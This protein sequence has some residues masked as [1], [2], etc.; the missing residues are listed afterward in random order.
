VGPARIIAESLTPKPGIREHN[1]HKAAV[2]GAASIR[3]VL[4]VKRTS[5]DV[6]EPQFHHKTIKLRYSA[7]AAPPVARYAEKW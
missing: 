7:L 5:A 6:Y 2:R 3:S 4:E 1:L